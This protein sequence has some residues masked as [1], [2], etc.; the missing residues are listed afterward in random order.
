MRRDPDGHGGIPFLGESAI[1]AAAREH[2]RRIART[3]A[4]VLIEG[5]TGT[6]KELAARV[7][8][9]E[10]RRCAG[11]F[12]PINCG[13]IPESLLES[14]L[15]GYRQGA[16]TDAKRNSPGVLLL[17]DGGTL[18]LDEVDSLSLRAQ[19]A[20]LRF[21]QDRTVRPLGSGPERKLDVR[22]IAATNR[23]LAELVDRQLF[24]QD[25]Y[26]RVNV[27]HVEMPPLR[28]RDKDIELFAT[29]FLQQLSARNGVAP[30]LLDSRSREW[31]KSHSWPGNIRELENLMEREFLLS[32]GAD[33]LHLSFLDCQEGRQTA[34]EE[35]WNYRQ[36]KAHVVEE[37]DRRFL[38]QLMRFARGNVALAARTS[39]KERRD[40]GR[41]LRKYA[42][43]PGEFRSD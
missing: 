16:F 23:K 19:V 43:A 12:I 9:Y 36:A 3:D 22:I 15:F 28:M 33:V 30:P 39:G 21:L 41:L 20:L 29:Y 42:I 14:E 1:F 35:R 7:L 24:R 26:Y 37:F 5:E 13:A 10:G 38:Q 18:F 40:L 27:M 4:T 11:P 25:L 17:A 34:S 6:G 31:L 2:I 32:E 8:H